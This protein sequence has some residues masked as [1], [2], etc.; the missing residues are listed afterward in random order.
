MNEQRIWRFPASNHGQT[1]GIS[2]GNAETFKKAP[3]Q[4]FAREILQNSIDASATEEDPIIV[5]FKQFQ[6]KTSD[7]PGVEDL[8]KA[9][10]RCI[11]FWSYKSDYLEEYKNKLNIL[12]QQFI[13]CLR[14]SDYNT[15]GLIG[16]NSNEQAKNNFLALTKGMGVSEKSNEMSGGSKGVGKNAAFL[17]SSLGT[18][19][20][21]TNA[22]KSISG[23]PGKF[24]GSLGVADFV[25]GYVNDEICENRDHTQGT[26]YFSNDDL[27]SAIP[28]V[29]RL[30]INHEDRENESGTDIFILGFLNNEDWEKEVINSI[31]DSFMGAIYYRKLIVRVNNI[32]ISKDTLK[33]IVYDDSLISKNQKAN[34][35]SQYRLLYGGNDVAI[36]PIDT[37]YGECEL[38][39]IAFSKEEEM[40]ATHKCAM[41]REPLMKIK[42]D[43][44]A[45][46]FNVSAMCV[47]REGKLGKMLRQIENPQHIDWEPKRIK[48][49]FKRKEM[50]NLL[51]SIREQIRSSVSEFLKINGKNEIDPEGAGEFLPDVGE[52]EEKAPIN[53][54]QTP[55]EKVSVS[56]IK[57]NMTIEKNVYIEDENGQGLEPEIGEVDGTE[58]GL[59]QHPKG[60]NDENT[61]GRHPG[62]EESGEKE[63]DNVIFKRKQLSGVRYKMITIDKKAGKNRIVFFA[64]LDYE[65]CYLSIKMLDDMHNSSPVNIL[66]M[67]CNGKEI[68]CDNHMEFGPFSIK[69]NQKVTIDLITEEKGYFG[70]EVKVICK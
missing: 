15:T 69:A 32:E 23:E 13:E 24:I 53:G 18:V 48:D 52:G 9:I 39:I 55:E 19:F 22:S 27:N 12:S 66:S 16:V 6:M 41:I 20:Y 3:F 68:I 47:I 64:P 35:I 62:S 37:E 49:K 50:E 51:R 38:K 17:M 21:S 54:N 46:N 36:Y 10:E 30:D 8:K 60:Q 43:L 40:L 57:K 58:W 33:E 59:V 2:D 7:I 44:V 5:E 63:G 14:V 45:Q 65:N 26:G 25:S 34:I 56:P 4:A 70:S 1:K 67:T 42:D 11:S 61:Q 31:L 29:F 28:N